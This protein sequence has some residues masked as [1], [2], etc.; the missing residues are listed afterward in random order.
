M[1]AHALEQ[2]GDQTENATWRNEYLV[3]AYELRNGLPKTNGRPFSLD[4]FFDHL[5]VRLNGPK[6]EGVTLAINI[7]TL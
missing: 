5:G 7:V 3:G 1:A 4:M 6:A 2:L